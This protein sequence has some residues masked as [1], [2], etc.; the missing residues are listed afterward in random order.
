MEHEDDFEAIERE[1]YLTP[2][3]LPPTES[4]LEAYNIGN[5]NC[6]V[7]GLKKGHTLHHNI[8]VRCTDTEAFTCCLEIDGGDYENKLFLAAVDPQRPAPTGTALKDFARFTMQM[9]APS[10]VRVCLCPMSKMLILS[11]PAED[12]KIFSIALPETAS[13]S[14]VVAFHRDGGYLR[15]FDCQRT[16][17]T[18]WRF[19]TLL[20]A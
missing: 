7:K 18:H 19:P 9:H 10:M 13:G 11:H 8:E 3:P 1:K 16:T 17:Q 15:I 2:L 5:G 12:Y 6:L 14:W 4:S 20:Q